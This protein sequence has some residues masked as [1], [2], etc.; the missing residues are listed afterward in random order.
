M[1]LTFK[2]SAHG[3]M[4]QATQI[5][6]GW[7]GFMTTFYLK[8]EEI[9]SETGIIHNSCLKIENGRI[10]A[11]GCQPAPDAEVIDLGDHRIVPGFV[12]L[13]YSRLLWL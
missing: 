13:Q 10:A 9:F 7:E 2:Q 1:S 11:V 4:R 12:D 5:I 3:K 8:A 6:K